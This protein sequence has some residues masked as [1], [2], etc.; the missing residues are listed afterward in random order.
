MSLA[1]RYDDFYKSALT[2]ET[3]REVAVAGWPKNRVEAIV[4]CAGEGLSVLDVGCAS[5]SRS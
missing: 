4:A 5:A 2:A 3:F 1:D